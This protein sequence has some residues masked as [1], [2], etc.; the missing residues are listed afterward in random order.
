MMEKGLPQKTNQGN[1]EIEL[2]QLFEFIKRGV[3]NLFRRFL[4]VFIYFK[5]NII[6]LTVLILV[7]LGIGFGLNQI[8]AKKLKTEVIV[9]PNHDSK[10]YLYDVVNEINANL[11]AKNEE[12]FKRLDIDISKTPKL[13]VQVAAVENNKNQQLDRNIEYLELLEKLRGDWQIR[14]L[15]RAEILN[16]SSLNHRITFFYKNP[17]LGQEYAQKLVNYINTN[18]YYTEM[19]KINIDNAEKRIKENQNLLIQIDDL[20]KRYGEQLSKGQNQ[21]ETSR[22]IVDGEERIDLTGLIQQKREIIVDIERNKLE[23][24]NQQEA[25]RILSFGDTQQIEEVLFNNVIILAPFLLVMAYFLWDL[26]KYLNG[27]ANELVV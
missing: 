13:E 1:D 18:E 20:I 3:D 8:V 9:K 5:N 15:V 14:D 27:K 12:F 25:I 26:L 21:N 16:T 19:T 23:I 4:R 2:G 6:I 11:E 24:L 7:G 22:V 17:E 10:S